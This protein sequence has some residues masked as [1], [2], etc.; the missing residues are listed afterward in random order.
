LTESKRGL[1]NLLNTGDATV[2]R[3]QQ[4]FNGLGGAINYVKI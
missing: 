3:L 4:K 1:N 2:S